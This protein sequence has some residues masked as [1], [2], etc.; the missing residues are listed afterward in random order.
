MTT[1]TKSHLVINEQQWVLEGWWGQYVYLNPTNLQH[2]ELQKEQLQKLSPEF[3]IKLNS[4]GKIPVPISVHHI[5]Q[6]PNLHR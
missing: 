4:L 6:V 1:M 5:D 2:P 3:V